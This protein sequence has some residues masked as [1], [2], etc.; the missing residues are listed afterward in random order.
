MAGNKWLPLVLVAGIWLG[1]LSTAPRT[2]AATLTPLSPTV[3]AGSS[4]S[5]T[6]SDTISGADAIAGVDLQVTFASSLLA[7]TSVTNGS[8]LVDYDAPYPFFSNGVISIQEDPNALNDPDGTGSV[9]TLTFTA[10]S[11]DPSISTKVTVQTSTQAKGV[12]EE[13]QL[14]PISTFINITAAPVIPPTTVP[15]PGTLVLVLAPMLAAACLKRR[16]RC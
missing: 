7:L 6:I 2:E 5:I 14:A 13:Y 8:L 11:A 12:F 3:V 10:L 1:A 4:V 16:D 15:E 9:L